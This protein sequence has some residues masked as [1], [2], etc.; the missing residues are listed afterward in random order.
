MPPSRIG[1]PPGWT[2]TGAVVGPA[3]FASYAFGGATTIENN[4]SNWMISVRAHRDFLP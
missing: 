3:G 4:S 2:G 1:G